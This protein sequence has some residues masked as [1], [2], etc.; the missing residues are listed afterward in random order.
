MENNFPR[1]FLIRDIGI[2]LDH[3][4]TSNDGYEHGFIENHIAFSVTNTA[5]E[6]LTQQMDD[7]SHDTMMN[8][9]TVK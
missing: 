9:I 5:W 1:S 8:I 6:S 7:S 3:I 2:Q 4:G